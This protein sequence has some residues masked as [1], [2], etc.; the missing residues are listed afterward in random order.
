M[1]GMKRTIFWHHPNFLLILQKLENCI[2]SKKFNRLYRVPGVEIRYLACLALIFKI[3]N[4]RLFFG[5]LDFDWRIFHFF[6]IGVGDGLKIPLSVIYQYAIIAWVIFDPI[7]ENL[8]GGQMD[9]P[10]RMGR[11]RPPKPNRV[12]ILSYRYFLSN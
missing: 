6:Y 3:K 9:P 1:L 2:I 5:F 8:G 7:A 4:F 11:F 12:K 10:S